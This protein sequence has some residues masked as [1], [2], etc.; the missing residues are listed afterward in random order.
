MCV[1]VGGREDY[2]QNALF[3]S[4][5]KFYR[6]TKLLT[7]LVHVKNNTN[8]FNQSHVNQKISTIRLFCSSIMNTKK[9]R[10]NQKEIFKYLSINPK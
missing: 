1:C 5:D 2:S 6:N 10:P 9:I 8:F 3:G 4:F 7:T